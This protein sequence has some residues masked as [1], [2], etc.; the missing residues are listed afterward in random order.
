[1]IFLKTYWIYPIY[2][3]VLA[4]I[5]LVLVPRPYIRRLAIYGIVFGGVIDLLYIIFL[6]NLGLLKY[7]NFGPFGYRS[8]PLFPIV[9]WTCFYIMYFYFLPYKRWLIITFVIIT[10]GSKVLF[11]NM[12]Q[13]LGILQW[14]YQSFI[15]QYLLYLIWT[16]VATYFFIKFRKDEWAGENGPN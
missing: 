4:F 9:A 8:I 3:S 15:L 10:S 1:V 16:S 5:V 2:T 13:N 6:G 11:S 7:I 14:T 12:L